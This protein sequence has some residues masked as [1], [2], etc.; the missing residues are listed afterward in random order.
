MSGLI[1]LKILN[2]QIVY[3]S[4]QL[5]LRGYSPVLR[6]SIR[7]KTS[8]IAVVLQGAFTI[9]ASGVFPLKYSLLFTMRI[10]QFTLCLLENN[11]DRAR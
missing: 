6:L 9:V 3:D 10:N 8:R 1:E 5:M 2:C 11:V 4:V 7:L